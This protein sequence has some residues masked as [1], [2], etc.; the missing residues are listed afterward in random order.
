MTFSI[1]D[2]VVY[3]NQGVATIENISTRSFEGQFQRFYL[4]RLVYSS[5]TVMVPFSNVTS[6]GIR[7]VAKGQD[8]SRVLEFLAGGRCTCSGDWKSRFK[9]N[10][11][12]MQDGRLCEVAEVLKSLLVLQAEKPLSFREKKMLDRARHLLVSELSIARHIGE[13]EAEIVLNQAL[14]KSGLALP[15]VL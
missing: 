5:M 2:K 12:K 11:D 15:A 13:A 9:E 3:P 7:R 6:V 1:G 8:V 4:L 10:T 14:R